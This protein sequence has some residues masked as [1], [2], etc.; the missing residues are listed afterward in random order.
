MIR[1]ALLLA[2]VLVATPARGLSNTLGYLSMQ[3]CCRSVRQT[4]LFGCCQPQLF[5]ASL[6]AQ[7]HSEVQL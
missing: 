5:F 4:R 6:M 2:A 3:V 7:M 1:T